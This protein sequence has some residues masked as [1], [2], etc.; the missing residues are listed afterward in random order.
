MAIL[1]VID[2]ADNVAVALEDIPV[3]T[4]TSTGAV[5]ET[6]QVGEPIPR[7]HKAALRPIVAGEAVVKHGHLIALATEEIP[8]GRWVHVHNA[9]SPSSPD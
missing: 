7:G 2:P 5:S 9:K 4:V 6:I 1:F 8:A 3:G